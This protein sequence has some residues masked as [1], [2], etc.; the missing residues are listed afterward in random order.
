MI[1]CDSSLLNLLG[2]TNLHP[3]QVPAKIAPRRALESNVCTPLDDLVWRG[4]QHRICWYD[5]KE[6]NNVEQECDIKKL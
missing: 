6:G 4:M 1:C 3:K 2:L 5:S